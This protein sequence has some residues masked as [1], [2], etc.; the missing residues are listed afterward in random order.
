[1]RNR[2]GLAVVALLMMFG[3]LAVVGEGGPAGADPTTARA[4]TSAQITCFVKAASLDVGQITLAEADVPRQVAAIQGGMSRSE[5]AF[6]W[7]ITINY[8]RVRVAAAYQLV[9][10]R[11]PDPRSLEAYAGRYN[12]A[13]SS[14]L[15][16]LLF[17]SSEFY[18][19]AGGSNPAFVKAVFTKALGRSARA[20]DVT[21]WT[22]QLAKGK[23]RGAV[24]TALYR[25][26]ESNA[27]RAAALYHQ[28]LGTRLDSKGRV[29]WGTRVGRDGDL[30]VLG[31]LVGSASYLKKH[32]C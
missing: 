20:S 24:A 9:F 2:F 25:S 21:Y 3:G 1:M 7:A 27:R 18:R 16:G 26:T 15:T 12:F 6:Q 23:S 17:G 31:Q 8:S 30:K 13:D 4:A 5:Y 32:H 22:G 10:G 11:D 19:K 14:V 29:Y 28:F